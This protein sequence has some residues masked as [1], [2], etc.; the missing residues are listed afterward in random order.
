M[1]Y[2]SLLFIPGKAAFD[3]FNME[4]KHGVKLYVKRVFIMDDCKEL[5]PEYLRFVK[6][7]V[8]SEDLP[9][10]VSREMLQ[11]NPTI[12]KMKKAL[13]SKILA[14]LAEMAASDAQKYLAFW[15]QFGPVFKE[16]LHTDYENK[17]KLLELVRFQSTMGAGK[18]DL[19]SL[20]QYVGRMRQDQKEIYYIN[21]ESRE[22]VEKS[23]HLE[24]F[25]EKSVEVLLLTD[26]IDEWIVNDI[27][28]FENKKLVSVTKGKL[29]LGDLDKEDK[30]AADKAG[31]KVKKLC[32]RMKN[33]LSDVVKDVRVTGRL[34]DSPACL[35][36]DENDMGANMEK[37]MRAMGQAV[38]ENKRILEINAGHPI[39]EHLNALYEK[40]AKDERLDEWVRL[41]YEQALIAEGQIVPDPLSYSKR[42]NALLTTV[43]ASNL[44]K[45][46]KK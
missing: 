1:E 37:I 32:E 39:V 45:E 15:Q 30:K 20:K 23:P 10:N 5:V 33:I 29:D 12:E 34:K 43:L 7:V 13:V 35:V 19:V 11:H 31:T 14:T 8:D 16:G 38:P 6:G 4:R 2:S 46:E 17:E 18:D 41:L 22:I 3:L 40:D 24:V 27:Y 28:N 25:K 44:G 9:L 21:G 36:A 26:P 42:V